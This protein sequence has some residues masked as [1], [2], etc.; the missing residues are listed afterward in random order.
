MRGR[1]IVPKTHPR[2]SVLILREPERTHTELRKTE[3]NRVQPEAF[4]HWP[5]STPGFLGWDALGEAAREG[6]P[7]KAVNSSQT[8]TFLAV[9]LP[10]AY[11]HVLFSVPHFSASRTLI[12]P[13][14][15]SSGMPPQEAFPASLPSG[16]GRS[17]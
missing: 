17:I 13:S 7:S 5:L 1:E 4:F 12:H 9:T 14:K 3:G 8:H 16:A 15:T 10:Y 2:L 11:A 6:L